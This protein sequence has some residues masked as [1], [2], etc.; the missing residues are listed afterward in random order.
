LSLYC[1][2]F[3]SIQFYA[4]YYPLIVFHSRLNCERDSTPDSAVINFIETSQRYSK[5][6]F[7]A[8]ALALSAWGAQLTGFFAWPDAVV[9]DFAQ[10]HAPAGP[11]NS[12]VLIVRADPQDRDA[13]DPHWVRVLETLTRLE[14]RQIVFTFLPTRASSRFYQQAISAGH[15]VFG[16]HLIADPNDPTETS[17][18]EPWPPT[19]GTLGKE[20]AFGVMALPP[21]DHGVYRRQY[22]WHTVQ[23]HRYPALE[24]QAAQQL[25][26]DRLPLP[27]TPYWVNFRGGGAYLPTI[28]LSRVLRDGLIPTVVRGRSVLIG[29]LPPPQTP[30]LHTPLDPPTGP[31]LSLLTFQGYALQTLLAD[32]PIQPLSAALTLALLAIAAIANIILYQWGWPRFGP[33]LTGALLALYAA[34]AW[35]ALLYAQVWLPVTALVVAQAGAFG[36]IFWYK[37]LAQDNAVRSLAMD[38]AARSREQAIP[39]GFYASPEPWNQV[40][41]LVRQTLDLTWL[42]F[43]ERI[44]EQ[45][46]VREIA[47]LNCQFADINER[48]RDYRRLPYSEAVAERRTV[49]LI[50]RLFLKAESPGEQYMTPLLFGGEL[51]GFWAMGVMPDKVAANPDFFALVESFRDQIAEMLYHRLQWRQQLPKR[52][53]HA[54]R[55]LRLEGGESHVHALRQALLA[56]ERRLFRLEQVFQGLETAAIFYSPFGRVLQTNEAM[57][58]ILRRGQLPAYEMTALDLLSTLGDISLAQGRQ[59]LQRVFVSHQPVTLLARV[60]GEPERRHTL[61]V[62]PVLASDSARPPGEMAEALPFQLQG[63][64]IELMDVTALHNL[65]SVKVELTDRVHQQLRDHLQAMLL[66]VELH[67]G[68]VQEER[69]KVERRKSSRGILEQQVKT[70]VELLDRAEQYLLTDLAALQQFDRYPV[71]PRAPLRA[72]LEQLASPAEERQVRLTAEMPELLSL[73]MADA[74][75]LQDILYTLLAVLLDDATTGSQITVT[76]REQEGWI[77]YEFRNQ[78]FGMP[79]DRLQ[80]W[81]SRDDSEATPLF[82]RLRVA[83]HQVMSWHGV[84]HGYSAL[85]EGIRFVVRLPSFG[86]RLAHEEPTVRS[87]RYLADTTARRILVIDDTEVIQRLICLSLEEQGY[88]IRAAADGQQAI[89]VIQGWLPD[90][91]VLDMIMPVMNGFEFLEWRNHE[92]P[93][94]PV[95]ALTALERSG[96]DEPILAAGADA[97]LFKPIQTPELLAQLERLLRERP[98]AAPITPA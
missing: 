61:R 18:L 70:A 8:A 62:R 6:A 1:D 90:L 5:G 92:H 28:E 38:L 21:A 63:V 35:L 11:D 84:L 59:I 77:I 26:G 10:R 91:I 44:P 98:I 46:Y 94:L 60:P 16:R 49:R 34:T 97:V 69:R 57:T 79:D 50:Q 33:W 19:V 24:N 64:L 32:Q 45:Y 51:L 74:D 30:G 75:S 7:V 48:R 95:L 87:Q 47:A 12:S 71:E 37:L 27:E 39:A 67:Q 13:A 52:G 86:Q 20:P 78:G 2:L 83:R 89:A 93:G 55:Y 9:Y 96:S 23:G 68:P 4:T 66:A 53:G 42:I 14:A 88:Q 73:A 40:V 58:A 56:F 54:F 17:R 36:V 81:L 29:L 82:R 25:A 22:A 43:L 3:Y 65:S 31:G 76:L 15:V 41:D 85:G 72:A 80:V